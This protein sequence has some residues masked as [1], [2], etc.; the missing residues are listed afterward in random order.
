[1][2]GMEENWEPGTQVL[3]NNLNLRWTDSRVQPGTRVFRVV[4]S[5]YGKVLVAGGGGA[6]GV[7]SV[8]SC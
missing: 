2:T 7:A 6:T 8:R 4:L 3:G 1:M 5:L